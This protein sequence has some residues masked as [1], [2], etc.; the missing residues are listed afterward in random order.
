MI[1]PDKD[2]RRTMLVVTGPSL[3]KHGRSDANTRS[4][5]EESDVFLGSPA[6]RTSAKTTGMTTS[7]RT[8]ADT[9][10]PTMGGLL[11]RC[12]QAS[13]ERSYPSLALK[14]SSGLPR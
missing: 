3:P 9:S 1:A 5:G 4:Q 12:G 13:T 7:V 11:V 2:L 8:V 10:P 6:P 14:A